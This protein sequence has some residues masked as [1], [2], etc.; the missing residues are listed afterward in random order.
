MIERLWVQGLGV[1]AAA[2]AHNSGRRRKER[3]LRKE[4]WFHGT[5]DPT[6]CIRSG[7]ALALGIP[8]ESLP[9]VDGRRCVFVTFIRCVLH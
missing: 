3:H 1:P 4:A 8:A 7:Y 9:P 6:G 2:V 5:A